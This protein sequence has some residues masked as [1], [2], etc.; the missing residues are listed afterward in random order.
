MPDTDPAA[1]KESRDLGG[2]AMIS[3][4]NNIARDWAAK[5]AGDRWS[6]ISEPTREKIRQIIAR[7]FEKR[8]E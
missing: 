4:A 8:H 3:P 7:S 6:D 2:F 1:Y 5:H